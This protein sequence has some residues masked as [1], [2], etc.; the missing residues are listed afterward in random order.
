MSEGNQAFEQCADDAPLD[1]GPVGPILQI[2]RGY[3]PI[4]GQGMEGAGTASGNE[5]IKRD[6]PE[7]D[8]LA[9]FSNEIRSLWDDTSTELKV[10]TT[11]LAAF[12]LG[13]YIGKRTR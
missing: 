9:D 6:L 12:G 7:A 10:G 11:A 8:V 4:W 1:A 2:I 13:V 3:L 5:P